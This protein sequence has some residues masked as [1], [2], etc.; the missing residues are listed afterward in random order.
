MLGICVVIIIVHCIFSVM[1]TSLLCNKTINMQMTKCMLDA[2]RFF[3]FSLIS[4]DYRL[5]HCMFVTYLDTV[6]WILHLLK[7]N[8]REAIWVFVCRVCLVVLWVITSRYH[9]LLK[10]NLLL[11]NAPKPLPLKSIT[12]I[13]VF[14]IALHAIHVPHTIPYNK[15]NP[16][17][18]L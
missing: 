4:R 8:D 5:H 7:A 6:T 17:G 18:I 1:V 2:W 13:N 9:L 10:E 3:S 15:I 11:K 12:E 16:S 14:L